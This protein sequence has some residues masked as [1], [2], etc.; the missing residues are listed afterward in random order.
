MLFDAVTIQRSASIDVF[1][2]SFLLYIWDPLLTK[3]AHQVLLLSTM[4]VCMLSCFSRV[5]FFASL[6]TVSSQ[7]PRSMEFSSQEYWS[8]LPCPPPGDLPDPEIEPASP[9]LAGRF[10]TTST[11]WEAH[12]ALYPNLFAMLSNTLKHNSIGRSLP[13]SGSGGFI[14][15]EAWSSLCSNTP[16]SA[17]C[18]DKPW[19]PASTSIAYL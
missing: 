11:T 2:L 4:C 8:G 5:Q 9:V 12:W 17:S 1:T 18:W 6:L 15:V 7:V 16:F 3:F 13:A 10:F 14:G 19:L